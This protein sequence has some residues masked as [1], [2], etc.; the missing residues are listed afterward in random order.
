MNLD[1]ISSVSASP[2]ATDTCL[3]ERELWGVKITRA[4]RDLLEEEVSGTGPTR[5]DEPRSAP[6]P[7]GG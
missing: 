7:D 6:S 4:L 1:R 5:S 2:S 3:E